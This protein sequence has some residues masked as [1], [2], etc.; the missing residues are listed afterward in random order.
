MKNSGN[1]SEKFLH[2]IWKNKLFDKEKL[3][4]DN[5]NKIEVISAG[6]YNTDA[7]PDFF[8]AKIKIED[9]IWAGNIEIH[10]NS[11]DWY[12]HNH[13]TDKAYNNVILQVALN[14][15]REILSQDNKKILSAE[16][17]FDTKLIKKHSELLEEKEEIPC[18]HFIAKTDTFLLNSWLSSVLIERAEQ[19]TK[20][21]KLLLEQKNNNWEDILYIIT[22]KSFGFKINSLPFEMLAKSLPLITLAK[23]KN[24]RFQIESLLF[25][26]AGM[27]DDNIPDDYYLKLKKE[28]KFLKSK[29]K[30]KP[31]E[32][33]LWKFLRIRPSNFPTVRISQFADLIYKTS[34]LFSKITEIKNVSEL[35]KIFSIKASKY[36]DTHYKFGVETR[37]KCKKTGKSAINSIIINSVIPV[38][39]LYGKEKDNTEI[40]EKAV[41]FLEN[42]KPEKNNITKKWENTGLKI[43]N[44]Y[45]S[46]SLI[47]LYNEYCSKKRCLEC[48]IGYKYIQNT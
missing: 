28:Y 18:K 34:H 38:L 5:G 3:T 10:I 40:T 27:L 12:K 47:Q 29:Y 33:H 16:L 23:H 8:S 4:D 46:Q 42:M 19:K 48:R 6:M 30:L 7:G 36:W 22:A 37:F 9:T 26:Q 2:Y 31:I 13:H 45:F 21:A 35:E 39:F 20:S 25:G 32:A 1:I 41:F 14:C 44:A 15:D 17:K 43:K 11:S 24:N